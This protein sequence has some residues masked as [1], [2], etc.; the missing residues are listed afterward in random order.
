MQR[1]RG[2]T[3]LEVVVALAVLALA[4]GAAVKAVSV[5]IDNTAY[6]RDKSFAH[7]VAMNKVAEARIARQWPEPGETRGVALMGRSDWYWTLRVSTTGDA[8]VRRLD[9][10]V[11]ARERGQPLEQLVAYLG[12]PES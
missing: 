6:L 2:F 7:W 10:S 12:R 5:S 8:D 1:S 3:L 11:A 9:V 4:L